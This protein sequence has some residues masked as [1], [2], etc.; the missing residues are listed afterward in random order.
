[1][2]CPAASGQRA[3]SS[4]GSCPKTARPLSS[5]AINALSSI[6]YAKKGTI[7][8]AFDPLLPHM[9]Q[10]GVPLPQEQ[11]IACPGANGERHPLRG[12]FLLAER[13]TGI[14]LTAHDLLDP[15]GRIAGGIHAA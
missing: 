2:G 4:F 11:G 7:V 10:Q 3:L 9:S 13:L 14:R 1:M 8:R 5:S 6:Q 12:A 15:A